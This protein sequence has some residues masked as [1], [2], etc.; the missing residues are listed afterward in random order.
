MIALAIKLSDAG[1]GDYWE[2]VDYY[3]RN[4]GTEMQFTPEDI[5]YLESLGQR[6]Q[7]PQA[8]SHRDNT[9]HAIATTDGVIEASMGA[10]AMDPFK[11]SWALCCSPW[12]AMG[13]FYAWEATLRYNATSG[14][15]RVNLLL[16]RASPWMDIDSH[17]PYQGKVV[18]RNKTA[19][20][21]FVRI[22]LWANKEKVGCHI[23]GRL[24]TPEW[25][26]NYLRIR[27]LSAGNAI[28]I[29]FP[30]EERIERWTTDET[31]IPEMPTWPGRVT[32][33]FRFRG[34]TLVEITPPIS[35]WPMD[36][37]NWHLYANRREK[38]RASAAPMKE[39]TRFATSFDLHW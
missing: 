2:D 33:N 18:L 32:R 24:I 16:N 3:I 27:N 30:V 37:G 20:E 22:P 5:P 26:G 28:T 8:E 12:G 13:L 36:K 11:S 14:V 34:N 25:F 15:A 21:A 19:K 31:M 29:E 6:K 1:I 23:A 4:H 9:V 17:L 7:D 35:I 39:V 38:Y 10:F